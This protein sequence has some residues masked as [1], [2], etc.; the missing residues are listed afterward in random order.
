MLSISSCKIV[1]LS[2]QCLGENFAYVGIDSYE[3]K[4]HDNLCQRMEKNQYSV[5]YKNQNR[6]VVRKH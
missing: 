3:Q 6:L 2:Y 4:K 5:W 1:F